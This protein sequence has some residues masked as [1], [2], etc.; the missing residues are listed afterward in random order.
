MTKTFY[1]LI[2]HVIKFFRG[3]VDERLGREK[4]K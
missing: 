4:D 3:V 1:I 2:K